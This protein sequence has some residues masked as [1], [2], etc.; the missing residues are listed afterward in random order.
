MRKQ[1]WFSRGNCRS[2]IVFK[3][4]GQMA[5]FI[6][7]IFQ[8]M[9]VLFAMSINIGLVVHDK[10][11]LQNSVDL[12]A[13]YGAQKQAEV[14]NAIAHQNY[15]VRQAWK[16]T[17]WRLNVLSALGLQ[18]HPANNIS[19][20]TE[21][22]FRPNVPGDAR[23]YNFVCTQIRARSGTGPCTTAQPCA[24]QSAPA[25]DNYCSKP[26]FSVSPLPPLQ[27]VSM[28]PITAAIDQIISNQV[29]DLRSEIE[30]RCNYQGAFNWYLGAKWV[31]GFKQYQRNN[32]LLM[33]ALAKNL[34]RSDFV[35]LDGGNVSEGVRKTFLKNLTWENRREA[36][37][38]HMNSMSQ[39]S[40]PEAWLPTIQCM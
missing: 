36:S 26:N 22:P 38:Q 16:L 33:R 12:A 31:F 13:Y 6:A 19:G 20:A 18:N 23:T 14:L 25:N 11:N 7:L 8:V 15:Q 24:W 29:Q 30:N 37:L 21:A 32:V 2:T 1:F 27:I 40:D 5:V 3:D 28:S 9:F 39:Y 35:T 34:G 17:S 4:N 10:I